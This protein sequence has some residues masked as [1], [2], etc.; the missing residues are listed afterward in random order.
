MSDDLSACY[1]RCRQIARG[2]R[3]S[4]PRFFR[5]LPKSKRQ[6]MDA[7]YSF[8]RFTDDLGDDES[9][10]LGKRRVLLDEWEQ[11]CRDMLAAP[12]ATHDFGDQRDWLPAVQ[13]TVRTHD[14]PPDTLMDVIRGCRQDLSKTE[15]RDFNEL[16]EYCHL[17]ASSVGLACMHVW[18][19]DG[20]PQAVELSRAAGLA[21]QLTNILRDIREDLRRG[22]VYLPQ[23][24]LHR[25]DC[26]PQ[27]LAAVSGGGE[28][29]GE[30]LPA[31]R[32]LLRFQVERTKGYFLQSWELQYYLSTDGRRI[33]P[34]MH[35][36]YRS[37]LQRIDRV[38]TTVLRR[39]VALTPLQKWGI[40]VKATTAAIFS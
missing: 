20:S 3:S 10:P 36:C 27:T 28:S 39:R 2:A 19:Y 4:F 18:G 17:V 30:G 11:V 25:F 7:L 23:D 35:S 8:F 32:E 22:R 24:E 16:Q 31:C 15:Y 26:S 5:L 29:H 9:I 34:L 40:V 13:D 21:F 38:G 12:Q 6:G 14:V 1:G 33:F 37:L